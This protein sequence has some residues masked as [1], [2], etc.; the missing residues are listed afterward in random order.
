MKETQWIESRRDF[1]YSAQMI[2][3]GITA[4][5]DDNRIFQADCC[6]MLWPKNIQIGFKNYLW[7]KMILIR[8]TLYMHQLGI[9]NQVCIP[10]ALNRNW[11][12]LLSHHDLG[13]IRISKIN[14]FNS[15]AFFWVDVRT[16]FCQ[17]TDMIGITAIWIVK[18]L[19]T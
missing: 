11:I 4:A 9:S 6:M 16:F 1:S 19:K 10:T 13:L 8:R 2:V 7:F 15:C 17:L 5:K 18:K 3:I 14:V 12:N